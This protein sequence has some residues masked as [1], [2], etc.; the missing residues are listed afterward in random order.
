MYYKACKIRLIQ[1]EKL[2]KCF[3]D[4]PLLTAC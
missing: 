2:V 3:Y 1:Q 4:Y